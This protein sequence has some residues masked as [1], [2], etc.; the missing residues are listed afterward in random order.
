MSNAENIFF[1]EFKTTHHVVPFDRI[2]KS[3]YEQ[4]I[5][6]AI[7]QADQEIAA[8]VNQR[9]RPTFEN[10]IEAL[11]NSGEMLNRTLMTF[12]PI[13]SADGDEEMN[14]ISLRIAPK[15][16]EHSANIS[17]NEALW[18]RIKTVY[19]NRD[20]L[21]LTTE[22]KMLLQHT[23]DSFAR[24]GANLEGADRDTYRK[25]TAEL[26][27][28]TLKFE[29]NTVKCTAA[30]ELWLTKDDLAGLP[31]S[32]VDAAALA[33]K[34]K[35]K[36]GQYLITLQQPTYMA[37][38]KYSS[39]RDLREKLY[40]AYNTQCIGGEFD[41]T[42]ILV[43]IAEVRRQI[44]K[45]LGYDSFAAYSLEDT[46][47]QTPENVYKL[48]DQLRDAYKPAWKKE[49]KELTDYANKLEGKKITL[50]AWDYSYYA[51][52]LKNEKYSYNEEELRPYF[53]LNN[54]IKGVFGL[55]TRLYG[56]HFTENQ[57]Y[58]V[59]HPEVMSFDVTDNDGNFVGVLYTDFFPRDTKRS[60]A[61]MT[62]F[63]AE[64]IVDGV[65]E[66]PHV[67]LT[68]NF[69]KPTET[70][71][72]LLTFYEVET[73][74]HEFGHGL[75]S[76]LTQAKYQSLSGT[77]VYR[78][79]VEVPSQFNENFLTQKEFLDSFARHYQTG[80]AIPQEL[81][82]KVIKAS[83]YGAA[84]ACLRQLGFGYL[85]MA[86]HTAQAEVA[87]PVKFEQEATKQV[88][89]FPVV[90]GC[91]MCPQFTHIF[92]GGYA[93]GYYSYKWA[94]VIEADAFQ[95]FKDNGIFNPEIAKSWKDNVLSR[96][97]TESPMVLY[98]RFRGQ[99]PTIDAL[100]IRDGIKKESKKKK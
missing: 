71:P 95:Y 15:L 76:L 42:K 7:K 1:E 20:K 62:E 4:A 10:T 17:L 25:L 43:R 74:I 3:F 94:E 67:T 96:G 82:D 61:W 53:E 65:S 35:G 98:K 70:K 14:E 63:R 22:Q 93:A 83:Q 31:E 13:L 37:F 54:V 44:A 36:D 87:D 57:N 9:S 30:Y 64:R 58:S 85:D 60:G 46:M 88:Q 90:E 84:H 33:A 89:M 99:E 50:Q 80:E 78:D 51:N 92:S 28:L 97:G 23:Y 16:S 26:S 72:S 12:Y 59:Y 32:A 48:L 47:A 38:M 18:K 5:D 19:D 11:E 8:I 29:Q 56:L 6:T 40:R 86:F 24:S 77:S 52:K 45:L 41:N 55:A 39:R 91:S 100:L 73:F 21:D 75:H 49:L 2:E 79:F 66:R 68:M 69:T 34:E 81:V 27:E